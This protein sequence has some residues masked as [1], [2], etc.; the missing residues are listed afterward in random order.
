VC[1]CLSVTT[2]GGMH[3][4]IAKK[5]QKIMLECY[6]VK[7]NPLPCVTCLWIVALC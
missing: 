5:R 1:V 7:R 4:M 6:F 2:M 3:V